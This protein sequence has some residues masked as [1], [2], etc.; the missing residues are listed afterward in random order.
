MRGCLLFETTK[1]VVTCCGSLWKLIHCEVFTVS[2]AYSLFLWNLLIFASFLFLETQ[3]QCHLLRKDFPEHW[4]EGG[5]VQSDILYHIIS[6]IFLIIKN[7]YLLFSL[8]YYL[9]LAHRTESGM[10]QRFTEYLLKGGIKGGKNTTNCRV[11]KNLINSWTF[12]RPLAPM[13]NIFYR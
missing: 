12:E 4:N 3:R 5:Q 8:T 13:T 6:F 1:F 11:I 7:A 9:I 2:S 10:Q